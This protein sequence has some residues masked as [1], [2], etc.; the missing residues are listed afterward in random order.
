MFENAFLCVHIWRIFNHGNESDEEPF[1]SEHNNIVIMS[2]SSELR[3][4][5]YCWGGEPSPLSIYLLSSHTTTHNCH[6]N[7]HNF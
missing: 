2:I 1:T 6:H 3:V 7:K 5:V 4:M